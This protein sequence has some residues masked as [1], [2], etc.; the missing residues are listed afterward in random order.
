MARK[1]SKFDVPCDEILVRGLKYKIYLYPPS[2]FAK[3]H[4]NAYAIHTCDPYTLQFSEQYC[5]LKYVKHELFHAYIA[6]T[7]FQ[8]QVNQNAEDLEEV[9][10][11]LFS[12][13]CQVISDQAIS[14][15]KTLKNEKNIRISNRI[16]KEIK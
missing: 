9:V 15:L 14:I 10:C 4:P 5:T 13:Y 1:T 7:F 3:R 8:Y 6:S 2:L 16:N 11:E 12:E